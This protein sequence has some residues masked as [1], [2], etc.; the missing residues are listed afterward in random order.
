MELIHK[1]V[2]E[3]FCRACPALACALYD[4]GLRLSVSNSALCPKKAVFDQEIQLAPDGAFYAHVSL[5]NGW[6]LH[7]SGTDRTLQEAEYLVQLVRSIERLA[8]QNQQLAA[9]LSTNQDKVSLLLSRLFSLN[10]TD[11]I[12]YTAIAAVSM[13]FDMTLPRIICLFRLQSTLEDD[14]LSEGT[15]QAIS[16]LIQSH[17]K[18]SDQDLIGR[19]SSSQIV[20][21][22]TV[23]VSLTSVH[24]HC[25]SFLSAICTALMELYPVSV[26]VG[27]GGV[28][29]SFADYSAEFLQINQV[30]RC[31][32][33]LGSRKS[34]FYTCDKQFELEM[35]RLPPSKAQHLL[36]EKLQILERFPQFLETIEALLLHN[37]NIRDAAEHLFVHHNTVVFRINRIKELLGID[38]LQKNRDLALLTMLFMY[39]KLK[40]LLSPDAKGYVP[41]NPELTID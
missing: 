23:P 34:F 17:S 38:P 35:L 6:L 3:R 24:Q 7:F 20:L 12:A 21:C 15:L 25:Q 19:V 37:M 10:T 8:Q 4:P 2:Y 1:T 31:E 9:E 32:A 41:P 29:H 40:P 27:I 14:N 22:K 39:S 30:M 5:T 28:C 33:L 11:D 26:Q 36:G 16:T 13:G 18:M